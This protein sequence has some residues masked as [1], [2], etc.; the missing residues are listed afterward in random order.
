MNSSTI[1]L[2]QAL[3]NEAGFAAGEVDG[4]RGPRTQAA[5]QAALLAT[6]QDVP[7]G[8]QDWSSRR[9]VVLYLQYRCQQAELDTG[10]LDG[11]WGPQTEYATEQLQHLQQFGVPEPPWRDPPQARVNP[12]GWP[13]ERD[14]EA[15]YGPPGAHLVMLDLPYALRLSWDLR[16]RVRRTQC[17]VKV[18]D[19]LRAVLDAV[20]AHYGADGIEALCLD[21]YGGGYNHRNK[22]GGSSL[23]THAY[24]IAFDFDPERNRLRWGR[25]QAAFAGLAYEPW[26]RCWE[27]E[28]WLSLGR[29][30]NFD[31]M[32]VQAARLD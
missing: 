26:W 24:G 29:A 32:H 13:L 20:L 14:L 6:K 17:H 22:R 8:W 2:L 31:W 23:S 10:P 9:Q 1:R 19:S 30:R 3:L 11:L 5:V 16:T 28:G 27:Q 4:Q 15:F 21:R 7:A 18:R 12:H 25:D